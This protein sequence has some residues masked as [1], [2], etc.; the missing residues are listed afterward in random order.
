[1]NIDRI[2]K[3]YDKALELKKGAKYVATLDTELRKPEWKERLNEIT[4]RMNAIGSKS[5][6]E[7]FTKQLEDLFNDIYEKITAPGLDAFID[8]VNDHTRNQENVKKLRSFLKKNYETYSTSIDEILTAVDSLPQE[9]EKLLFNKL[10]GEFNKKLKS[11]VNSFINDADKFENTIDVFL[12]TLNSEYK[13][14]SEI[15]ELSYTSIDQLYTE[16]Q[17]TKPTISF[18]Q[19][20][21]EKAKNDN[22]GLDPLNDSEKYYTLYNLALRRIQSVKTCIANLVQTGISDYDDES[23]KNLFLR[24]DEEMLS[25]KGDVATTLSNYLLKTWQPLENKYINIRNFY[26]E[27]KLSFKE[28]DW[29][30]FEKEADITALYNNYKTVRDGNI[31]SKIPTMKLEDVSKNINDCSKKINDLL[32]KESETSRIVRDFFEEFV[33]IY[34]NKKQMLDKLIDKHPNL[35]DLYKDIYAPGKSMTTITNGIGSIKEEG[36][37]LKELSDGTIY[38][39]IED[40]KKIKETFLEILKQSQM[41]AQIKWLN[42]L[43]STT[44]NENDFNADYLLTLIKEGLITLSFK[45]EF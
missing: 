22:Q 42:D 32:L 27:D 23:L 17:K 15:I 26:E 4:E 36:T 45:K 14:M 12:S 31:L 16:N 18:Y 25:A 34:N 6:F 5:D 3:K 40:M 38:D 44:I 7:R 29:K 9:D 30:G 28:S 41:E 10:I 35:Q 8:W 11:K 43:N 33:S 1:M 37:F 39:M 24:Y 19:S 2:E 21:I 13:G 20:I